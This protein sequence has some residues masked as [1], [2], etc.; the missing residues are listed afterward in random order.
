MAA[1]V[2]RSN[3]CS[4]AWLV[5]QRQARRA[6][7]RHQGW[8]AARARAAPHLP[9]CRSWPCPACPLAPLKALLPAT[10]NRE[11]L[12]MRGPGP[13][14]SAACLL[15]CACAWLTNAAEGTQQQKQGSGT[16]KALLQPGSSV[17]RR[18]QP[19]PAPQAPTERDCRCSGRRGNCREDQNCYHHAARAAF[20]VC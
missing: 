18:V 17:R 14:A 6:A 3:N 13:C 11:G 8:P 20:G 4:P 19:L 7:P 10:V 15:A 9:V 2:W 5:R 1:A 12:C 16:G